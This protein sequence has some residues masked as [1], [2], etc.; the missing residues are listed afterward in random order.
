MTEKEDSP[1]IPIFI[2]YASAQ[3][4]THKKQAQSLRWAKIRD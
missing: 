4:S 1:R 2:S 3:P